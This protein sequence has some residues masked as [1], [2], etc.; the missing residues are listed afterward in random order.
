MQPRYA[1]DEATILDITMWVKLTLRIFGELQKKGVGWNEREC[2]DHPSTKAVF[3][4][5]ESE[6]DN[7]VC[8][9]KAQPSFYFYN[10]ILRRTAFSGTKEC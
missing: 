8:S 10:E 5:G 7:V 9:C 6:T 3:D 1:D 2:R 4:E